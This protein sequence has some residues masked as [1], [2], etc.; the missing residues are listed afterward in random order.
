MFLVGGSVVSMVDVL[1]ID[2]EEALSHIDFSKEYNPFSKSFMKALFLGELYCATKCLEEDVEEELNSAENYWLLYCKTDD[3]S[4]KEMASDEL[5]H[6]GILIKKH[7]A[8]TTDEKRK[9]FLNE[10]E[11]KRQEMLKIVSTAKNDE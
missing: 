9:Y 4:Y 6:A 11:K 2:F 1:K 10:L 8:K 3:A 5:K 7:L